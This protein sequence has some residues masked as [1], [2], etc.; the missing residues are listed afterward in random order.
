VSFYCVEK[1][2][3]WQYARQG[4]GLGLIQVLIQKK[5]QKKLSR[6]FT[7]LK[8][9]FRIHFVNTNTILNVE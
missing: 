5:L 3:D 7:K 6:W 1:D 8:K 4:I 2:R 9:Q